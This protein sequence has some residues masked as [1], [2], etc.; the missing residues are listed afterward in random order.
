MP[1]SAIATMRVP[2]VHL[3][4]VIKSMRCRTATRR[5]MSD[6]NSISTTASPRLFV[7]IKDAVDMAT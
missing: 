2:A 5:R 7:A 4:A 1:A 6:P 3:R